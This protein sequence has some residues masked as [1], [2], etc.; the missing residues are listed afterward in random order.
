MD[1]VRLERTISRRDSSNLLQT[2]GR[3]LGPTQDKSLTRA[4]DGEVAGLSLPICE[5]LTTRPSAR[6]GLMMKRPI[7]LGTYTTTR[8][9]VTSHQL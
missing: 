8:T 6:Y 2:E 5:R 4:R 3:A 9:D 7:I 1:T